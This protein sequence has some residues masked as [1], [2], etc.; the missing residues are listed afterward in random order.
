M[1]FLKELPVFKNL[2]RIQP[3][4]GIGAF[5]YA[6]NYTTI[7]GKKFKLK[8][9]SFV[10]S[11]TNVDLS[12]CAEVSLNFSVCENFAI[13]FELWNALHLVTSSPSVVFLLYHH[14]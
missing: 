4:L 8:Y 14:Y 2:G 1:P 5:A 13:R 10:K 6:G 12:N 3:P 11:G 7:T 9:I